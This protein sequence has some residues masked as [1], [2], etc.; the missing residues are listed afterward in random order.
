[1]EIKELDYVKTK[2]GRTGTVMLIHYRPRLA[3]EIE[4]DG[5]EMTEAVLPQEI[6]E[7]IER[8]E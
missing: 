1:L 2:D 5:A 7:I 3:Y 8:Y 6:I 4:F